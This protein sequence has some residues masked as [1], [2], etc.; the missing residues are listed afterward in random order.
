VPI[1]I[2]FTLYAEGP[3]M[4]T[5]WHYPRPGQARGR[6]C[7]FKKGRRASTSSLGLLTTKPRRTTPAKRIVRLLLTEERRVHETCG[8]LKCKAKANK[9]A[10]TKCLRV[11]KFLEVLYYN[12]ELYFAF[13]H[14]QC[15]A[16]TAEPHHAEG[17]V[18]PKVRGL[19]NRN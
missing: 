1:C 19:K 4:H 12:K 9:C 18:N 2:S 3:D 11:Y 13:F 17:L 15:S 16:E 6:V 14:F 10:H 7:P 8:L 5:G